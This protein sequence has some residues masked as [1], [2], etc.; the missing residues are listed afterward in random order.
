MES[1]DDDNYNVLFLCLILDNYNV[2]FLCLI[3]DNYNVLFLCLILVHLTALQRPIRRSSRVVCSPDRFV[4]ASC[5]ASKA[6]DNAHC[7]HALLSYYNGPRSFVI[8]FLD[9]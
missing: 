4:T 9:A 2:L 1:A 3:L 7:A 8:S 5:V 6:R